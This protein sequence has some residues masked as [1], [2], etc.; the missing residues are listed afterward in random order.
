MVHRDYQLAGSVQVDIFPDRLTI[1]N[2]GQLPQGW[3]PEDLA[4]R[5]ESQP[6][7][8]DICRVFYLRN[9]ME[10]LGLGT[11]KLIKSCDELNAPKP[12]WKSAKGI[13]SLT[14]FAAP[15]PRTHELT[16][17]QKQFVQ[18]AELGPEF[19]VKDYSELLQVSERQ[20][21]R[22]LMELE[23]LGLVERHGKGP[24]TLYRRVPQSGRN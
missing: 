13:V 10:Q 19:K 11:Q 5:H 7:N 20:A 17:R 24:S 22:D 2:P 18:A 9:L 23:R 14:L 4:K 3:T 8:P 12:I 16:G 1:H 15:V 6:A 21:R